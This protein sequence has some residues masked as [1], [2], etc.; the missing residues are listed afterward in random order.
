MKSGKIIKKNMK[1]LLRSRISTLV[2]IL[3]PLLIILLVGISFSTNSFNLNMGA[4][5]DEY[6]ELSERFIDNLNQESFTV[7]KYETEELCVES[8]KEQ[9]THAC[10]IFPPE[11]D[12]ENEK[13]N[14]IKF[15]VDQSKINLVYLVMSTLTNSFGEVTTDISKDL[16]DQI[17]TALF[18]TKVDLED[19]KDLVEDVIEDNAVVVDYSTKSFSSL[20]AL[21]LDSD[22]GSVNL[23]IDTIE[24][25]LD[26]LLRD[27]EDLIDDTLDY[28][29]NSTMSGDEKDDV[30]G[31]LDD[32]QEL[33][34]DAHNATMNEIVD[35]NHELD[36]SLN[37]LTEK[38]NTAKDVND[39]V[40][41]KLDNLKDRAERIQENTEQINDNI[42]QIIS[43]I[44]AIQ[45]TNIENIV[46][47]ISTEIVPIADDETNL[48]FLFPSLIVILIMFIGLLLPSTLIIMEKNS[49]ASFRVFTTPTKQRMFV[50]ATYL[51]SIILISIQSFIILSVSQFY[52]NINFFSSFFIVFLALFMIMS[53]FI[54]L[55]M[56]VGYL[57]NTEEMAMLASVSIATL[58]LLTSGII[59]PIETMSERFLD[60]VK[61]NPVVSGSDMFRKALLFKSRVGSIKEPFF[62]LF[63][64]CLIIV[65]LIVLVKKLEKFRFKKPKQIKKQVLIDHFDFGERKAKT[66]AE[67]IISI[68]NMNEERFE[69][70]YND[71]IIVKWIRYIYKNKILAQRISELKTKKEILEILVRELK[72]KQQK[73]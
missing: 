67:F 38:L 46:S 26:N 69:E 8:V 66:L 58:L 34:E 1:L 39:D 32:F 40:L 54:L 45:I 57:F 9:K 19:T 5:S 71:E 59:F 27:S 28:L 16:T 62:Y 42:N 22:I 4:Y 52:F 11:L 72:E 43:Y 31:V 55:G 7:T 64:W 70:Y 73:Q 20:S 13:T 60:K 53:L 21:D 61:Y 35:I 23:A 33:I 65:L 41:N 56:L 29:E 24:D 30:E 47:P 37:D 50:I 36:N 12:I 17:V 15:H 3:G 6:S 68:Q 63:V 49:K 18:N 44:G 51:T 25:E 2:L 10:I 14:I 48:G